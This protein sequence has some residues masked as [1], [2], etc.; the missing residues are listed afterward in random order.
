MDKLSCTTH[1]CR[2]P[3]VVRFSFSTP[4]AV[5]PNHEMFTPCPNGPDPQAGM[6]KQDLIGMSSHKICFERVAKARRT[7]GKESAGA[8]SA[9]AGKEAAAESAGRQS[10]A[11]AGAARRAQEEAVTG[12][13]AS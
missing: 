3:C 2:E 11:G 1:G 8:V 13:E 12:A 6:S 5:E 7:D 9:G 4:C 10:E